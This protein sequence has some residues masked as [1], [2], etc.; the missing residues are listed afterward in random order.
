[1]GGKVPEELNF[2]EHAKREN[3]IYRV[4]RIRKKIS[5]SVC[6]RSSVGLQCLLPEHDPARL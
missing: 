2:E 6:N 5:F 3:T 1:M 4:D